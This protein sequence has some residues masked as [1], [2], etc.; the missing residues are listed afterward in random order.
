MKRKKA[1]EPSD[2]SVPDAL[3]PF[4]DALAELLVAA[5]VREMA[6]KQSDIAPQLRNKRKKPKNAALRDRT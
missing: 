1:I 6:E 2:K 3:L 5:V 4:V